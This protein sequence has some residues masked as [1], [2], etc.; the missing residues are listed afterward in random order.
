MSSV[1]VGLSRLDVYKNMRLFI[2]VSYIS[3][4]VIIDSI[5][6]IIQIAI[7]SLLGFKNAYF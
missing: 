5:N 3:P 1:F 6:N 2:H 4:C 7:L